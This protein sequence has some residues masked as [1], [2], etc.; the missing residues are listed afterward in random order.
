VFTV[1]GEFQIANKKKSIPP[2]TL[3]AKKV[4]MIAGGTGITPMYQLMKHILRHS[5]DKTQLSL[6]FANQVC[7][8][9]S[10]L[11]ILQTEEDILIRAEL[12]AMAKEH[13]G[14]VNIWYT[15][16]RPSAGKYFI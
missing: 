14:R 13:K 2:I 8:S 7:S 12:E 10:F 15:L 11:S 4:G 5:D 1:A 16:D 3:H 6:I 9:A